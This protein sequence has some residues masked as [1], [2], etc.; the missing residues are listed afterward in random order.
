MPA[1][2]PRYRATARRPR[3]R[4]SSV[5][6]RNRSALTPNAVGRGLQPQRGA[7]DTQR[8]RRGDPDRAALFQRPRGIGQER[9]SQQEA[10]SGPDR[11]QRGGLTRRQE[12]HPLDPHRGEQAGELVFHHIRQR[13]DDQ[14]FA[15]IGC[16][17]HRHQRGQA[18]ILALRECRFDPAAGVVQHPN[19]RSELPAQPH[20]R[21]RKVQLDDLRRAGADQEQQ[22]DIGP[23]LQ[24]LRHDGVQFVVRVGQPGKV[25]FI[26][27]RGG[28]A[29]FGEDHHAG[30]GLDQM[31]AGA[32]ADD[33]EE[34]VLD[35][36]VQPDDAGQAAENLALAAFPQ[37]RPVAANVRRGA[38]ATPVMTC[39]P[40]RRG[41]LHRCS[42]WRA[43]RSFSTNWVALIT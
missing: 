10:G 33:Q 26:D 34:R 35:F 5:A 2:S 30:G 16:R 12:A 6:A 15:G 39:G 37:D 32:R 36:A 11:R 27:D 40:A 17:Q 43:A 13:A 1:S 18:G 25:A 42:C 24:Q 14:Q 28:E 9:L 29:R 23:P 19:I 41:R 20:R 22:L 4:A 7:L 21:P 31:R 38:A 3:S 8:E